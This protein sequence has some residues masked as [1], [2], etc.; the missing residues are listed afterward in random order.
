MRSKPSLTYTVIS[1]KNA[2]FVTPL[3]S[4]FGSNLVGLTNIFLGNSRKQA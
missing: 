4:L 1:F 2:G 3:I